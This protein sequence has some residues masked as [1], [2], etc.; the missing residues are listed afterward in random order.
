MITRAHALRQGI[1]PGISA[2]VEIG[3]LDK[4]VLTKPEFCVRYLDFASTEQLAAK[5]ADDP[6]VNTVVDVDVLWDGSNSLSDVLGDDKV[7][8]VVASHVF[9]HVP[10]PIGWLRNLAYALRPG[11]VVALAIPDKRF[12]FDINRRLSETSDLLDAFLR[13]AKVASYAQIYDFHT[14]AIPADAALLWAGL[15]D[16]TGGVRGG[17]LDREAFQMCVDLCDGG[18]YIDAHCHTFTPQSFVDVIAQ[19]S[20]FDVIDYTILDVIPT[21]RN[22][23]EF[24][25]RLERLDPALTVEDRRAKQHQGIESA[26]KA[27]AAG[28]IPAD[29][30]RIHN[31]A[32]P[33][34]GS[35]KVSDQER[36]MIMAK[37]RAVKILRSALRPRRKRASA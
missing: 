16:Y 29:A 2:A 21:Q 20:E 17:D 13:Q 18:P 14:K 6:N 7:D 24:Y 34:P 28:P 31:D 10:D 9:E 12:T 15:V 3:P 30:S 26:L 33:E 8:A 5:Y 22:T 32:I 35:F 37:R 36:R 4:P 27:I 23:I 1:Q 11:G 19:L 25:A